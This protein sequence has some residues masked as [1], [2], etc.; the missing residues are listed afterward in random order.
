MLIWCRPRSATTPTLPGSGNKTVILSFAHAKIDFTPLVRWK[1]ML[2]VGHLFWTKLS[3]SVY[4]VKLRAPA[5]VK[6]E[7]GDLLSS[8][9]LT[10][11]GT[12]ARWIPA[13]RWPTSRRRISTHWNRTKQEAH[14]TA[15]TSTCHACC[16]WSGGAAY[17]SCCRPVRNAIGG[18]TGSM[19][20]TWRCSLIGKIIRT[21]SASTGSLEDSCRRPLTSEGFLRAAKRFPVRRMLKLRDFRAWFVPFEM[22]ITV[23]DK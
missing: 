22:Q 8:V 10:S 5:R 17:R 13:L 15:P 9:Y 2:R 4:Q 23:M 20:A 18:G 21:S 7:L 14:C 19:M 12:L 11:L 6:I 3:F 1:G 16:A